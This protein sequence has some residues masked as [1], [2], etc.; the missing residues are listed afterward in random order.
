MTTDRGPMTTDRGPMKNDRNPLTTVRRRSARAV[1]VVLATVRTAVPAV[2]AAPA[3][4]ASQ[5]AAV[6]RRGRP[7]AAAALADLVEA[8]VQQSTQPSTQPERART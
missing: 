5:A 1:A 2:L 6:A 4:L 3:L 8:A 7:D